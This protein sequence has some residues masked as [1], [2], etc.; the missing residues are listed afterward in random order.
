MFRIH[1]KVGVFRT[2]AKICR[3]NASKS[4]APFWYVSN[5]KF[6]V[7]GIYY[8]VSHPED[9]AGLPEMVVFIS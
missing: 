2:I 1:K 5:S 4:Q 6:I 8:Y 3:G 9:R 7:L